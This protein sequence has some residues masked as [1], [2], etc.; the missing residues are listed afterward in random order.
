MKRNSMR[1]AATL[2]ALLTGCA[3]QEP[4]PFT[5]AVTLGGESVDAATL[6][7]GLVAYRSYCAPCHGV[8]G[9]GRG[10]AAGGLLTP[11]RDFRL[12]TY[13]F[14]QTVPGR[15]P[16][17]EGLK[18]IVRKGL[19][20]TAMLPW[21]ISDGELSAILQYI[22]TFSPAEQGWRDEYAEKADKLDITTNPWTEDE[23]AQAI[24]R[25]SEV[26]HGMAQCYSCHPA[27]E[28]QDTIF[29]MRKIFYPET[30]TLDF[31]ANSWLPAAK[32]SDTY[33]RPLAEEALCKKSIDCGDGQVCNL[34]RCE[35]KLMIVPPD[36]TFNPLRTGSKVEDIYR[37]VSFGVPGTAM[38]TWIG[39]LPEK[40]L[41]AMAHY[42]ASLAE[43]RFSPA[44]EDLIAMLKADAEETKIAAP[45]G[46]SAG[47]DAAPEAVAQ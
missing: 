38:P 14:A 10:H 4:A 6:N 25:G 12:A 43:K 36:F 18:A 11:P 27:Y 20:G 35:Q 42:V 32:P 26:Y 15:L 33:T 46:D 45:A 9:D 22:K 19:A 34:G 21:S 29:A 28:K 37:V 2:F 31:R 3:Y 39:V 30:E 44:R 40:D 5:A 17:D 41:W 13:K 7:K 47:G 23:R 16:H 1:V 8:N 24:A